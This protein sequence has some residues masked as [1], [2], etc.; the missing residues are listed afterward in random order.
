ME[1]TIKGKENKKIMNSKSRGQGKINS[2]VGLRKEEPTIL[3]LALN[4]DEGRRRLSHN[5]ERLSSQ[6]WH[7]FGHGPMEC[8][9]NLEPH[10]L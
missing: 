2:V 4:H 7:C 8:R 3:L 9:I 1:F 6:T 10:H 5:M